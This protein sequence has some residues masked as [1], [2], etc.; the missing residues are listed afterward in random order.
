MRIIENR[1]IPFS[2][3]LAINIFGI[4]FTKNLNKFMSNPANLRHERTHTLQ[5]KELWY[6]GFPFVYLYYWIRNMVCKGM[7]SHQAYKH[8]PLEM[9]AYM[10]ENTEWYNEHREKFAW[11]K[12]TKMI[13]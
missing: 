13:S 1:L 7:S 12:Y 4:V 10:T 9:E 5:Y 11:K 8:I 2:G 6:V 3:Y